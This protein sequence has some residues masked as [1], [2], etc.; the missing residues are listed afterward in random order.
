M[1][2]LAAAALAL[3]GGAVAVGS[4]VVRLP[5][6]V[7]PVTAP[8]LAVIMTA[9][10][11][12]PPNPTP[13]ASPS[14]SPSLELTWTQL[15]LEEQSPHVAW[16]G[17]RFVLADAKSGS[18]RTSIDGENWQAMQP[19]DAA[20]GYLNLLRG[21]LTSWQGDSVGIWNPQDGPDYAGKS[22]TAP[23][24]LTVA[25]PSAAPTSSTP[26]KGRIESIGIGPKGIV[27][28]VHSDLDWDAWVTKKL[29]LRT[30]NDWTAHVRSVTFQNGV[31]Q[32]KLTNRP[33]LKVNWADQGF[34]PGDY[35][36]RGFGWYSPDGEHWTEMDPN[37]Q[38]DEIGSTM[39]T[40]DFGSVL[41]V[42][43]GFIATG[44]YPDGSCADPSG[45]CTGMWFSPDGLTWR[46]L[47]TAPS[48]PDRSGRSVCIRDTCHDAP[49]Q[50]LPWNGG[51]LVTD[52]TDHFQLWTSDG[53]SRLPLAA[54][55]PAQ[56]APMQVTVGTGPLGIVSVLKDYPTM[57]NQS[58]FTSPNGIDSA[59]S[60]MPAQMAGANGGRGG[61]TVAVGDH[62]VLVLEW[63]QAH[64][65]QD[66]TPSLWLGT[67]AP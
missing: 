32:I 64:L 58:A 22:V 37:A 29:G 31:L 54:G 15:P 25:H 33:G 7:P 2:L 53:L 8:S 60:S 11:E 28:E 23:D 27:A 6:V 59:L 48:M 52:G 63:A 12:E 17:D 47:G 44:T 10:P 3:V 36:D 39:P 46:F 49:G 50:L 1:P 16:L 30:N 67:F 5:S 34:E 9:S 40:G 21:S 65:E 45:L 19:G 57:D 38:A 66:P 35:Q 20:Q 56:T 55:I 41:G 43:D 42:S 13:I 61:P 26:F 24:I 51:A 62:A 4:G 18:V 14:A